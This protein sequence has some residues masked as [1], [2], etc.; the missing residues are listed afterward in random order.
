MRDPR[1][2]RV[3]DWA[4]DAAGYQ[5]HL[6]RLDKAEKAI[7][8]RFVRGTVTEGAMDSELAQLQRARA[9]VRQQLA[10]ATRARG[11]AIDARQ[12]IDAA[13]GL[14]GGLRAKVRA[15]TP[16]QRRGILATLIDPGGVVLGAQ[17]LVE[18][19]IPRPADARADLVGAQS[20]SDPHECSLR[21]RVVA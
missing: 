14:L 20:Y 16:E 5:R 10:T 9:V 19:F 1:P 11:G 6:D 13:T 12:R 21:I 3:R 7:L 4:A 2:D 8:A 15:A 17:I 18:L